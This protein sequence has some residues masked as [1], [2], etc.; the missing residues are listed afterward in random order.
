L[1]WLLISGRALR[2]EE[3][4]AAATGG[5]DAVE[6]TEGVT[7][8][9]AASI[10]T[11][12]LDASAR[13]AP[14]LKMDTRPVTVPDPREGPAAAGG[15]G[16]ASGKT[17]AEADIKKTSNALT[18]NAMEIGRN[19]SIGRACGRVRIAAEDAMDAESAPQRVEIFGKDT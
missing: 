1:P 9:C 5:V 10:Q 11:T 13:A 12:Q 6:G 15:P 7:T 16:T 19:H 8:R 4:A 18:R 14:F 3:A 17:E 2:A